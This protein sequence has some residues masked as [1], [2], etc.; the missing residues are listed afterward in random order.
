MLIGIS[1]YA[2]DFE[3]VFVVANPDAEVMGA[4]R[5]RIILA[6]VQLLAERGVQF[7]YPAQAAFTA[8]PDGRL[9]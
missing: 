3:V 2:L 5:Q 9:L 1:S 4:A 7:A 8:G 6:L